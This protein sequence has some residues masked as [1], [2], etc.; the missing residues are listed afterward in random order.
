MVRFFLSF[1]FQFLYTIPSPGTYGT[2]YR[3][4]DKKTGNNVALKK[5]YV[6]LQEDGIPMNTVREISLLRQLNSQDHPNIVRLLD[7][8]HGQQVDGVLIMYL[9]FE[10][11]EQDLATYIDRNRKGFSTIQIRNLSR[12]ILHGVDF[13]HLNRVV[14]RDL[15]PQNILVTHDGHIKLADFGLAKTY[16]FEMK[17]T[18]VVRKIG[19]IFLYMNF[20][21]NVLCEK[22]LFYFENKTFSFLIAL[23]FLNSYT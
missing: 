14:H 16:D 22:S 1:F 23:L 8:C 10:H 7:V 9:V 3:A 6:P 21:K 20:L 18:S 19:Y 17:L 5:V 13:L 4:K 2:V 12:E 11:I 15:K